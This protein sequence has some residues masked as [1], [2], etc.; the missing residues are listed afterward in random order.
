MRMLFVQDNIFDWPGTMALSAYLQAN[1]HQV[2]LHCTTSIEAIA[3]KV[4]ACKPDLVGF[5]TVTGQHHFVIRAAR[6]IR[7]RFPGVRTIAGGPHASFFPH[8]IRHGAFDFVGVNECE[9]PLNT[10]LDRMSRGERTD[11]I[12]G[13]FAYVDGEVVENPPHDFV[14][15]LDEL[16]FMD[17]DIYLKFT[18]KTSNIFFVGRGCPFSCTFCFNHKSLKQ[19][20]DAGVKY[21]RWRS[22]GNVIAE[23]KEVLRTT[24]LK[25]VRFSDDTFT[26]NKKY[27]Q[28]FLPLYKKEIGLPFISSFRANVLDEDLARLLKDSGADFISAS[29]EC[30]DEEMRTK[31]LNKRIS[32]KQYHDV[33]GILRKV[34]LPFSLGNM[35]ALPG[36][37]V[38]QGFGTIRMNIELGVMNPWF[39]VFQPYPSTS[40][41]KF[42][43]DLLDMP[44]ISEDNFVC[45][46]Y[47]SNSILPGDAPRQ[48]SNLHKFAAL[49]VMFPF[50]IPLVRLLIKLP[51]NPLFILVHRLC[52]TYT[53]SK[54]N[55]G[56]ILKTIRLGIM[57]EKSKLVRRFRN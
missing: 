2:D 49:C 33:A 16:P 53:F 37:T 55:D 3:Q 22:P 14:K 29:L 5:N 38:E 35:L 32:N 36:E 21:T 34:D 11:D 43:S 42:S 23:I 50:L 18:G 12:P 25:M 8:M 52:H 9:I 39:S 51:S 13:V 45:P 47:H 56:S 46:D 6:Q 48:L 15:N 17:R 27:L 4:D 41:A 10:L 44:E 26:I 1:G 7:D 30:A 20:T 24:D 57:H 40:L 31:V 54:Y 19:F 28:E